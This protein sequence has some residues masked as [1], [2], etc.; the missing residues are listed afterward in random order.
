MKIFDCSRYLID[1]AKKASC[2]E[3][4]NHNVTKSRFDTENGRHFIAFL[5]S[6]EAIQEVVYGTTV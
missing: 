3:Q 5:F 6:S 2:L 1:K 4:I